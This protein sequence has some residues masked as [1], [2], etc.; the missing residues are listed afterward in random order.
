MAFLT[1]RSLAT[2]VTLN[3]LIH[4]VITGDTSQGNPAGSS[5]KAKFSQVGNAFSNLFVNQSGDTMTGPLIVP[6]ISATTYQNLPQDVY[7]TGMTF[8]NS[9][10]D[11]T[12][13][14]NDGVSFTD[15]L[16]ILASEV[17]VTGGTYN[18]TTGTVTFINN[19]GGTFDVSGFTTGYTDVKVTAY[20]YNSNTF[21]IYE[22]DGS[23]HDATIDTMTGLTVNGILSVTGNTNLNNL[24]ATTIGS[25][26]NCVTDIYATNIRSCS[27]LHIQPTNVGDVFISEN[28][29]TVG[30]GTTSVDLIAPE[31]LVLSAKSST[32][33]NIVTAKSNVNNYTQLNIINKSNGSSASADVVA[34]NNTG[35][36]TTNFIDMGINS[37]TF[38][39]TIG[40]GND[41][42]LYSTGRELYIGNA[43]T[44][45]TSNIK[46]FAGN[47]SGTPGMTYK[48]SVGNFGIGTT[49]P[50]EKLD[51]SGKTKT[52]T[53]QLTNGS[54]TNYVLLS[55]ASGNASWSPQSG[56]TGGT[57]YYIT[58]FTYDNANTLTISQNNNTS[59][60]VTI[61]TVTGLTVNGNL[62]VT[63]NTSLQ[64]TT[65]ST[66]NISSTPTTDTG[67]T[68]NY[69]TIDGST[70]EVKV[71][72]IPGP[73]VYGL[74][75]QT[76]NSVAVSATTVEGSIIGGGVGTLTVGANQFRIGDSFR[77]DFGGLLSAKNNDTIRIR[78]KTLGGVLLADS[79]V[80]TM[81]TSVNDVFQFTINFTIRKLGVGGV[82]DIVSLGVFHS[83]KQ[84]NGTPTGFAF[85]T[86]NNTTF[87][88]TISNTLVVTAQFSSN[89]PLNSIYSDIFVLNKI[90]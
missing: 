38:A 70:G 36:E 44:G 63:G 86:V 18:P 1:D 6:T 85:N 65:A 43:T 56:I 30:I 15:D 55:D 90:F 72:T 12:I 50:T 82:S 69:L 51:V 21:T 78:V 3:D 58:G 59:G 77:C 41:A 33:Y 16:S 88:T 52:T 81:N 17:T 64:A 54:A 40:V 7:V 61:N 11:L 87:D 74:F 73:T 20:T 80:Q 39:G 37:S 29:G 23:T 19:T 84:S 75:A 48:G 68:A 13:Y 9:N 8:N 25:S 47:T 10:Y 62:N 71:K 24:S 57:N 60:S 79:G 34:T 67:L 5:Y 89:S 31:T 22:T 76:G 32:S 28:G 42:Y 27:P 46:F 83:T 53:F 35:N 45:T 4:I 26:G 14:R 2:G 49:N 66:L